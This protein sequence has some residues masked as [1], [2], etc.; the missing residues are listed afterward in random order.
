[1]KRCFWCNLNNPLYVKIW[2]ITTE[3]VKACI[4]AVQARYHCKYQDYEDKV[5]DSTILIMNKLLK[6]ED[7]PKN[8]VN[9]SYLPCLGVCCGK[10]AI[11]QEMEN[12]SLSL[13]CL[14]GGGDSFQDLLHVDE[15]GNIDYGYDN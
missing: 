7:T 10:K 9:L 5:M 2:S 1:M 4:G 14:T 8:I 13:D 12:N 11:A 6:M 3:V 15:N